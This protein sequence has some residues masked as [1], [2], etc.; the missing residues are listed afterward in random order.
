MNRMNKW[1]IAA[2]LSAII[3]TA[4]ILQTGPSISV[5][6]SLSL[7]SDDAESTTP[8]ASRWAFDLQWAPATGAP[9]L[10]SEP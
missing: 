6:L 2:A 5:S 9:T 10:A 1:I 7:G 3:L 4:G 8:A